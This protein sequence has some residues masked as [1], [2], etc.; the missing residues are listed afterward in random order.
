MEKDFLYIGSRAAVGNFSRL[1]DAGIHLG[2]HLKGRRFEPLEWTRFAQS[3]WVRECSNFLPSLDLPVEL[4]G[5]VYRDVQQNASHTRRMMTLIQHT[6]RPG[7]LINLEARQRELLD[8]KRTFTVAPFPW[9]DYNLDPEAYIDPEVFLGATV[10]H[11]SRPLGRLKLA[12]ASTR[13][14]VRGSLIYPTLG[15]HLV[16]GSHLKANQLCTSSSYKCSFRLAPGRW[17]WRC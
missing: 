15:K 2:M 3:P 17:S 14:T 1:W 13:F 5:E 4:F 6:W 16:P 7:Q 12:C 8:A 9:K 10:L 11:P